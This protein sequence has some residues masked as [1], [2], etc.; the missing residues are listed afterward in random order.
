MTRGARECLRALKFFCF[1]KDHCW[2]SQKRVADKIG[3]S[4]GQT[5]RYFAELKAENEITVK[6]VPNSSA[7]YTLKSEMRVPARVP[8]RVPSLYSSESS[9]PP[10]PQAQGATNPE[11]LWP[12]VTTDYFTGQRKPQEAPRPTVAAE[13]R[14][15]Y[16]RARQAFPFAGHA[17]LLEAVAE[18]KLEAMRKPPQSETYDVRQAVEGIG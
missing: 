10:T 15:L 13:D 7:V 1:G 14:D 3:K 6:R 9:F 17:N 8:V 4:L 11:T 2:P 18:M 16:R 5:R 12:T